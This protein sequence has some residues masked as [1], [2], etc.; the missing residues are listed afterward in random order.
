MDWIP[1]RRLERGLRP[2]GIAL[3]PTGRGGRGGVA[4]RRRTDS[5]VDPAFRSG[6]GMAGAG[7]DRS[8]NL[9]AHRL[10]VIPWANRFGVCARGRGGPGRPSGAATAVP[11]GFDRGVPMQAHCRD[12]FA[13]PH[14]ILIPVSALRGRG[15]GF[16]KAQKSVGATPGGLAVPLSRP[17]DAVAAVRPSASRRR[18]L[19]F[20]PGA[21]CHR[22]WRNREMRPRLR[23]NHSEHP[24]ETLRWIPTTRTT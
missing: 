8:S 6:T 5:T 7:S 22:L 14:D 21:K 23:T 2:R 3:A 1:I 16:P 17:W 9:S 12:A 19:P 20:L 10:V 15:G 18:K 11:S 13:E 4:L 24:Y